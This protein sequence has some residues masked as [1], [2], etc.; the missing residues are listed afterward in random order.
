MTLKRYRVVEWATGVV[1][2]AAL[3]RIID[4]PQLD[5]VGVRVYSDEKT[6]RD[7]GDL[8]G[9]PPTGV[10]A[11]QDFESILDLAPDCV[12]Y[13]PMP[14]DLEE[15]CRI[16]R[17]GI[18]IVTPCPYWF[19]FIQD[20]AA[21]AALTEACR[22]GGANV[23]AS[24]TNPGGVAEQ[25]PLVFSG[26]CN[27]IDRITMTEYGDC[28][29][30]ESALVIRELMNLGKTPDEAMNNPIKAALTSFWYEPIDMIA[31]GLGSE[32]VDYRQDHDFILA[33]E[34]ID[35]AAGVIEAGTIALNHYQHTGRTREGTEIV[36]EQIWFMDDIDQ[37]RLESRMDIPRASGW[38]IKIE[39]DVELV[40]DIA[41]APGAPQPEKTAQG[42]W[43]TGY[44][45]VNAVPDVCDAPDPG[46]KTFL[47]LPMTT[48]RMGTRRARP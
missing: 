22:A 21:T 44:H 2:T 9:R 13:C 28:R 41:L 43:T 42:L 6:G 12:V 30:Y 19:P 45:C 29:D 24:G 11:T 15:M 3:R 47:D 27:R 36:Q 14:W 16:L 32:V 35:T 20:P 7:A 46:I 25:F 1:G 48:G 38:R 26:W 39:G 8:V 10:V 4:H 18:H 17:A 37:N 40:V 31:E 33:R 23:F 5:L 34:P